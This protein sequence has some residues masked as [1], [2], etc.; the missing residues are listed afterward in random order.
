MKPNKTL[1]KYLALRAKTLKVNV[2]AERIRIM[3]TPRDKPPFPADYLA[4]VLTGIGATLFTS[5][6]ISVRTSWTLGPSGLV[7]IGCGLIGLGTTIAVLRSNSRRK[8][9]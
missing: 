2:R 3:P 4:G 1:E 9:N 5:Y 7:T 6:L 8:G